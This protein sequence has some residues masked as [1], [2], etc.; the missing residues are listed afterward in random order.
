MHVFGP[1]EETGVPGGNPRGTGRICKLHTH[2]VE[3]GIEPQPWRCE[4]NMLTTKPP[5]PLVLLYG[6]SILFSS[7]CSPRSY[8]ACAWTGAWI[9]AQNRTIPPTL[10]VCISSNKF[11]CDKVVLTELILMKFTKSELC[12]YHT[13]PTTE[14]CCVYFSFTLP[15]NKPSTSHEESRQDCPERIVLTK[16]ISSR[17][18]DHE[19]EW[20]QSVGKAYDRCLIKMQK[21]QRTAVTCSV[22]VQPKCLRQEKKKRLTSVNKS[23]LT[24]PSPPAHVTVRDTAFVWLGTSSDKRTTA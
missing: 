19:T 23:A 24:L 1:G 11:P 9:L 8:H 7:R 12:Y 5:R 21:Q 18:E 2:K 17:C 3:V 22:R 4:A 16:T 20:L 14:E 13:G 15:S 6:G 10:T